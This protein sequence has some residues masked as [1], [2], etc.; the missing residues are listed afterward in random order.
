MSPSFGRERKYDR[1]YS[2]PNSNDL[3]T[4]SN[5]IIAGLF[6]NF[7]MFSLPIFDISDNF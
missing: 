1:L 4:V 3:K 2:I 6:V 7:A 5:E